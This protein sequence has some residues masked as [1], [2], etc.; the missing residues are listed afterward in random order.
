[1]IA[2]KGFNKDLTCTKGK[3]VYQYTPGIWHETDK[4][5]CADTGFHCCENPLDCLS[6]YPINSGVIWLVEA[7]GD[8]NE[9]GDHRISCTRI[10]LIRALD[11]MDI[12]LHA[13]RYIY[14]HPDRPENHNVCSEYGFVRNNPWVIVRGKNPVASGTKGSR[15]FLLQ[16][17]KTNNHIKNMAVYEVDGINCMPGIKYDIDGLE[18]KS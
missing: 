12:A 18:V 14:K 13:C 6:Y 16:E 15:L 3:G 9:D 7:A 1:M 2:Y 5:K 4:A 17:N 10:R 11:T 8:I